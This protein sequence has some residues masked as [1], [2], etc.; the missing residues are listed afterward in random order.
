MRVPQCTAPAARKSP[1]K[2]G[3][4]ALLSGNDNGGQVWQLNFLILLPR[5]NNTITAFL[6][7]SLAIGSNNCLANS[8]QILLASS[9]SGSG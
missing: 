8:P 2:N 6:N 4:S 1:F 7:S 5:R 9:R 3:K